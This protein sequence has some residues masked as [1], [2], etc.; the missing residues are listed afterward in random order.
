MLLSDSTEGRPG[1]RY[2][3]APL[4]PS[5]SP[6]KTATKDHQKNFSRRIKA[7]GFPDKRMS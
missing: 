7:F 6:Q 5:N 1:L 3:N 2:K 4:K